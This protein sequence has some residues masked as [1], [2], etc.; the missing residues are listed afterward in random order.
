MS[1]KSDKGLE[2]VNVDEGRRCARASWRRSSVEA[3]LVVAGCNV[4]K[5]APLSSSSASV[6]DVSSVLNGPFSFDAAR[7][8]P[9][10]Q[11]G[12]TVP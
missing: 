4:R 12:L 8:S 1:I 3:I 11:V 10:G 9:P 7:L 6:F 5:E 2:E